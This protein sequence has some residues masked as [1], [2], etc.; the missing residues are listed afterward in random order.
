MLLEMYLKVRK[1]GVLDSANNN[2]FNIC[3]WSECTGDVGR[4]AG[5]LERHPFSQLP[6]GSKPAEPD[7]CILH[8]PSKQ[9]ALS[10]SAYV[11]GMHHQYRISIIGILT[12]YLVIY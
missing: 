11:Y 5:A 3:I 10:I 9:P 4:G 1:W 8:D 7:R 2:V 6:S 12:I